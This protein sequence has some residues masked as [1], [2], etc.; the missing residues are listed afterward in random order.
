MSDTERAH[1]EVH[2][3]QLLRLSTLTDVTYAVGLVLVI[4]WLPLPNE[5]T[6]EG[7]VGIWTLLVEFSQNVAATLIGLAFIIIY[8]LRSNTLLGAVDRTNWTHTVLS[9]ASVA[10][11]LFLLYVLRVSEEVTG[12]SRRAGQSV[13]T[14]LIGVTGGMAWY[15]ARRKKLVIEGIGPKTQ[16]KLQVEAYAEPLAALVTIPLAFLGELWWNLGWLAYFPIAAF[17][18]RQSRG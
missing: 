7:A 8:W 17:L 4:Q 18:R 10:C 6:A 15:W 12:P 14:G 1:T 2:R 16:E 11:M 5:S 3:N 13:A 9:I